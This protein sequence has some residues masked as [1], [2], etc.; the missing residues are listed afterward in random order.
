VEVGGDY[1]S[2]K[3]KHIRVPFSKAIKKL[4]S[5]SQS[6]Q[7]TLP[8]GSGSGS[9]GGSG[10]GSSSGSGGGSGGGSG[11]SNSRSK[12]GNKV[13]YYVAQQSLQSFP[14]MMKDLEIPRMCTMTG[15][16]GELFCI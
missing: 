13:H 5:L 4:T 8:N 3:T 9:G 15:N 10:S 1:M 7:K 14:D 16:G 12:G 11:R 2:D 6:K